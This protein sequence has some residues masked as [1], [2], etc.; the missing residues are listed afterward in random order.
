MFARILIP[1]DGLLRSSNALRLGSNLAAQCK[2]TLV[3]VHVL[4]RGTAPAELREA[5]EREGFI[6]ELGDDLDR[7]EV[8]PV[9]GL[10]RVCRCW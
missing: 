3:L 2:A 1:I 10:C 8:V 6:G 4:S 7:L 5:A 9:A